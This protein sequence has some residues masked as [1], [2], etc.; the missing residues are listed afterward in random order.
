VG[1]PEQQTTVAQKRHASLIARR[2]PERFFIRAT[3]EAHMNRIGAL[4]L[5]I[6]SITL[7]AAEHQGALALGVPASRDKIAAPYAPVIDPTNF[8]TGVDNA[9][10]PLKPGT[11]FIYEGKT[12]QGFERTE[13][14]VSSET[15]LL[16]GVTCITVVTDT[17][18]NGKLHESTLDW[19]AQ[20]KQGNVWYFGEDTKEYKNGK[21]ISTQGSWLAG[22]NGAQPGYVMKANPV[23]NET[24]RQEFSKGHAEDMATVLSLIESASVPT[25]SYKNLL[26]TKEWSALDTPPVF[27]RKYYAKGIGLVMVKGSEGFQLSLIEIRKP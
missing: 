20:D 6:G 9:Y 10:F 22:V 13:T 19:Y 11:T 1:Q 7:T 21:V 2:V 24:Y 3:Q 18:V 25:G 17:K 15:K 4:A 16:M 26:M 23:L 27:E 14:R 12:N 8:V 5:L